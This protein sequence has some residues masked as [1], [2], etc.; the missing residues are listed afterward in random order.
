M[1]SNNNNTNRNGPN[2]SEICQDCRAKTKQIWESFPFFVRLIFTSTI[3]LYLISF[4]TPYINFFLVNIP[5]YSIFYFQIWRFATTSLITTNLLSIVL[6]LLFWTRN[7]VHSERN[8]GTVKYMLNFFFNCICIQ[9]IYT[10][11]LLLISLI[12]RSKSPLLSKALFGT[13]RN[14][15][16][17]PILMCEIT[18]RCLSNPEQEVG[19][20]FFPCRFKAKYYPLILIG[21][22]TL[23][24]NFNIDFEIL[25]GVG[26]GFLYHYYLKKKFE[27]T[28]VFSLKAENSIFCRWMKNKNGFIPIGNAEAA[29]LPVN[30]VQ[31]NTNSGFKAFKGKG[32]AVGSS[33]NENKNEKE[34][35]NANASSGDESN[36]RDTSRVELD[37][38][39]NNSGLNLN[40]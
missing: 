27:I 40:K 11:T 3:T 2:G 39:T 28:D 26:F 8:M 22:F 15:G 29:V 37:S 34:Y 36:S 32:I 10:I 18:L 25:S 14:S 16:L 35:S 17:W 21:I 1:E 4:F 33:D 19:F 31:I 9:L 12:I 23:L 30:I 20:F 5:Y 6:S 38:T 13:I 24:S 7:S